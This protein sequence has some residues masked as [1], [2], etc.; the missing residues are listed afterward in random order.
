MISLDLICVI[1]K[2][3]F[4]ISFLK[5]YFLLFLV[6]CGIAFHNL[7]PSRKKNLIRHLVGELGCVVCQK[8]KNECSMNEYLTDENILN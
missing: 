7:T 6:E 4:L 3:A 5:W 2:S 8:L 1:D